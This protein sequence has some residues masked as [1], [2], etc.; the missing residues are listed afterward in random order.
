MNKFLKRFIDIFGSIFVLIILSPLFIIVTILIKIN[1]KGP[2]FFR[3]ERLTKNGKIFKMIKFRSMV[4]NA[5]KQGTGL[6]NYSGDRRVTRVGKFLRKTSIDELPQIINVL[7]GDMSLVGPRPPVVNEIGDYTQLNDKYKK[8]FLMK[9]GI[10]GLAQVTGRNDLPW[11]VKINF[12]NK[13]IDE[14][15]K[16][17]ILIDIK[18]VFLTLINVFRAKSIYENKP[19]EYEGL[20]D[21]E[22]AR[23]ETIKTIEDATRKEE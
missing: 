23:L 11:P 16:Y 7:S 18:I 10:T 3:Q 9:G 1:S 19:P 21:E 15:N 22:V 17:G 12:D 20:S 2:V 13:Y 6:F 8:R 5:E 14:F 4:N